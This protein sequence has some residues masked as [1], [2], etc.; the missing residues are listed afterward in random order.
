MSIIRR[1]RRQKAVWWER[2]EP[3]R[4]GAFAF[5]EPIEIDCRWDDSGREFRNADGQTEMS[6]ATVYPDRILKPGDRLRKGE[7]ETDEPSD[8]K[9]L[10]NAFEVKRFDQNPNL[11]NTEVLFTAYLT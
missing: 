7:M 4:Y 1:M 5:A 2:L 10:T 3:D 8:P 11:R 6:G 9:P